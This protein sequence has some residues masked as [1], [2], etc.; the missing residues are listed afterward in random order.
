MKRRLDQMTIGQTIFMVSTLIVASLV[1]IT[2]I[3]MQVIFFSR[4]DA[5]IV[6][7]SKEINKQVI[8]NY[9]AYFS[10]VIETSNSLQEYIVIY[11]KDK[12]L[13]R[14]EELFESSIKAQ[15]NI[16]NIS[17]ISENGN[18]IASSINE[19]ISPKLEDASWFYEALRYPDIHHFSSPHVEDVI[20]IGSDE[21]ISVSKK[22]DYYVNGMTKKA[23]LLIELRT[24]ELS[25]IANRTNLGNLG[26]ILITDSQNRLVFDSSQSCLDDRCQSIALVQE[27]ILGG[28][29]IKYQNLNMYVSVNTLQDTRWK[30]TTL[31]NVD[32]SVKTKQEILLTVI[33]TFIITL[34]LIAYISSWMA[35]RITHPMNDLKKH[36]E[37]LETGDFEAQVQVSGQK[38]VVHL[39]EAFNIMSNKIH[40]LMQEVIEE[41]NEKRKTHFVAL[42]NQI[43]PH[44]LYNTLD[45]IVTLSEKGNSKDVEKAIGALSRFFRISVSSDMSLITLEEE[46]EHVQ[47]YLTIQQLRYRKDFEFEFD[48]PNQLKKNKV[49]KLSLQPLVE[50]AILYGLNPE[51]GYKNIKIIAYDDHEHIYVQVFNQGFGISQSKIDDL[52]HMIK[53]TETSSSLG[54]KNV[55]QRLKLYFGDHADLIIESELDVFTTVTLKIPKG[56]Q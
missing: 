51:Q 23:I 21:V 19:E 50:N 38:E 45:S 35:Q 8:L 1:F 2:A 4:L 22:V 52:Y 43:N 11:T 32:A 42:Q 36:I 24:E 25:L 47:H 54:L 12:D 6:D 26:H 18:V 30:I 7:T 46:I 20:L 13:N 44:F 40:E 9:E 55:Y 16:K 56:E 33:V 41:Q 39:A 37:K 53:S 48:I 5:L 17:L 29:L 31:I 34:A 3:I 49:I 10:N 28:R 14:L 15:V 27:I